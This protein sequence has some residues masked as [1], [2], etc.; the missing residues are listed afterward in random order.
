MDSRGL[1]A[2]EGLVLCLLVCFCCVFSCDDIPNARNL[3]L[4]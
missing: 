4:G 1:M 3:N 2:I